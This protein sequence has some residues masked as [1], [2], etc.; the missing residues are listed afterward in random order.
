[1]CHLCS[2]DLKC[3][4]PAGPQR[5]HNANTIAGEPAYSQHEPEHVVQMLLGNTWVRYNN[6]WEER[7]FPTVSRLAPRTTVPV[8]RPPRQLSRHCRCT[9]SP[10]RTR[11]GQVA[12]DIPPDNHS[13]K[14]A[15][16]LA[17]LRCSPRCFDSEAHTSQLE[18]GVFRLAHA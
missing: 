10:T 15:G 2:Q 12:D 3:V 9:A 7:S 18:Y 16:L 5:T 13:I 11:L 14:I 4:P 6:I 8:A 17:L 1:M